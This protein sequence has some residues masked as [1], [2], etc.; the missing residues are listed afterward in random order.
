MHWCSQDQH[1]LSFFVCA[2]YWSIASFRVHRKW[3]EEWWICK[4]SQFFLYFCF[5]CKF[6]SQN[7]V[8]ASQAWQSSEPS[9][10]RAVKTQNIDNHVY[11]NVLLC[12]KIMIKSEQCAYLCEHSVSSFFFLFLFVGERA[13]ARACHQ[14]KKSQEIEYICFGWRQRYTH[15]SYCNI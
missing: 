3:S 12:N 13:R 8:A 2:I 10:Q 7:S 5:I 14:A 6:S 15:V 9:V 4:H 1:F 11:D